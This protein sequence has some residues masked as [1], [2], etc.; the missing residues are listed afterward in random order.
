MS[1]TPTA[2]APQRDPI[3]SFVHEVIGLFEEAL[4][5][6]RFPD[7]DCD[8]LERM[9]A[10]TRAAQLELERVES[11]LLQ[12][13]ALVKEQTAVLLSGAERGLAYARVFAQGDVALS[14]RIDQLGGQ[15][16]SAPKRTQSAK[17]RGRKPAAGGD[18]LF[19]DEPAV[20]DGAAAK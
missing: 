3:P 13:Q 18:A 15:P 17:K 11:E 2:P 19:S 14:A 5:G 9:A 8:Q 10:A 20:A 7:L 6:V 1:Q 4:D 12:A 16:S